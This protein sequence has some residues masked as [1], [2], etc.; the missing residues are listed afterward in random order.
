MLKKAYYGSGSGSCIKYRLQY[1]DK[2]SRK[3]NLALWD[4][5]LMFQQTWRQYL[6]I[7]VFSIIKY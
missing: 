6:H 4:F 7:I 5:L 1:K 3:P 2:V